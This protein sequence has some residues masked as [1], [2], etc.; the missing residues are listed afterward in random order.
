M[1]TLKQ[2][3]KE[4]PEWHDLP[5]A[6]YVADG[7]LDYIGAAGTV[8]ESEDEEGKILVFAAN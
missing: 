6:V 8:Y 4:H 7:S 2:L 3:Y 5:M 1:K